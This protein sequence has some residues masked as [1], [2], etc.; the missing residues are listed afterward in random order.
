VISWARG[1]NRDEKGDFWFLRIS[2]VVYGD[3]DEDLP[4][5]SL[6]KTTSQ[7]NALLVTLEPV[8][9][10]VDLVELFK[11]IGLGG[12]SGGEIAFLYG[13]R[14]GDAILFVDGLKLGERLS[15]RV[16]GDVFVAYRGVDS[17]VSI[18]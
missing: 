3:C 10:S 11:S 14:N 17:I 6:S 15:T 18:Q 13:E 7:W 1:V 5:P 9:W 8:E 2:T 16:E 4:G 12:G